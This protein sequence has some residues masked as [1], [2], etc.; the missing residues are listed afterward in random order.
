[1]RVEPFTIGDFI[2]AYN[3]GN[4]KML[5]FRE[6][7][8][9]WRFLKILR[10][11]NDEYSPPQ[12]FRQLDA[13]RKDFEGRVV[14][15]GPLQ[16]RSVHFQWP[17]NWPARRPLVKILA[18]CLK[19]NHFHLLLKEI[20]KGGIGKFMKKVGDGFTLFSNIKYEETGRI[21]QGG[22]RGRTAMRDIKI[23][24]YLDA[25]IQVFNPFES[26]P[27]GI[28]KALKE[29]DKAFEFALQDPFS[30]LGESFGKRNTGIIDRDILAEMFPNLE[31]YKKFAY[32]ALLVR[33]I[34]EILGKLTIE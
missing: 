27:G 9:K 29:F 22:Y 13:I 32:D 15:V 5:V 33:N 20:I 6:V 10:F 31:V 18:Y 21:F 30:S 28:E 4:R 1:M 26:Y 2:H 11:F 34:R 12:L 17:K 8:D 16:P 3:R 14:E 23:L 25:Y 24:Q 7:S 19:N